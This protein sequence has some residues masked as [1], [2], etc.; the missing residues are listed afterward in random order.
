MRALAPLVFAS[1]A[2]LCLVQ[3][4]A[5]TVRMP[6][7]EVKIGMTGVG[8]TVF[9]G[10][11]REEFEVEVLGVLTNVMGP[12]RNIIVA[13]LTG[14]PLATT[15]V[16]QGMSGSPVYIDRRLVGA[17]SYSLG[18]FSTD[19]IAGITPIEE[20]VETDGAA[21]VVARRTPA[22]LRMP[23]A[24]QDFAAV[25]RQ[26]F[27]S[28]K[29]FAQQPTD[30]RAFGLPSSEGGRLGTLLQPIAT[31]LVLNGFAPELQA[32]WTAAF[33]VGGLATTVGGTMTAEAQLEVADQPLQPGDAIGASLVRGDL[34]M[35]GTGTVT[36]I[37]G[38]R[39]YAFG[40]PFYNLGPIRFPMT[41]VHVTT[42]LPSLALSSKIAA[43]GQVLGTID[44]DRSTGIY[45]SLG[46]GPKMIP[47]RMTLDEPGRDM[48]RTFNF[49][50]IEDPLFS[51]ILAYTTALSTFVTWTRD[52][53]PRTYEVTSTA[54][55]RNHGS[56]T[57]DDIYTGNSASAVAAAAVANP[58][59]TL[60]ANDFELV[61]I[62]GID[63]AVTALEERQTATLERVWLDATRLRAGDEVPLRI[64]SR[65]HRGS[66]L[67]ETVMVKIPAHASGRLVI[68]VSDAATLAVQE[69]QEGRSLAEADSLDQLIRN[70]ND[71]RRNNRIYV[72]LLRA[73]AGAV[74]RGEPLPSLPGS[75]LAVLE[76]N[77]SNG[78]LGRLREATLGEW[79]LVGDH[80]VS[81]SRRLSITI[82]R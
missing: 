62:L 21:A 53:G 33:G 15:G 1:L 26:A 32:V 17:V 35:A 38:D 6:L 72:R 60:F 36:M 27:G 16:I 81:G 70:L 82:E 41:R 29:A 14:G 18:S 25:V 28:V 63:V 9:R 56:V 73:D 43:I 5:E 74:D 31:P 46:P 30:V 48:Q 42:V 57:F 20:M 47:I 54:R 12:Q 19:A 58:V 8:I 4:P 61:E 45:G 3:L 49:E 65:S 52:L 71:A 78:G 77:R 37:E 66:E 67:L 50:I 2:T 64:L 68:E 39:V 13:R 7:D 10:A 59:A 51:P 44:Q 75:V 55:L 11:K 76:G 40:H 80:V 34:T 79:E 22:R 23:A 24:E 69:Q